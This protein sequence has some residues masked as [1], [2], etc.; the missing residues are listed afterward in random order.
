MQI[1]SPNIPNN[2]KSLL[3]DAISET[4]LK[5]IV[6]G[7]FARPKWTPQMAFIDGLVE[8]CN[9]KEITYTALALNQKKVERTIKY[10]LPLTIAEDSWTRLQC[11]MCTMLILRNNRGRNRYQ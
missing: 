6:I 1:E 10:S 11:H 5:P 8:R 9:F 4:G 3:L 7:S 2:D